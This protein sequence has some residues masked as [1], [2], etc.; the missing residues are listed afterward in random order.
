MF[1]LTGFSNT[2][3]NGVPLPFDI[4]VLPDG[5]NGRMLEICGRPEDV[6]VAEHVHDWLLATAERLWRQRKRVDSPQRAQRHF[7]LMI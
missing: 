1:L 5:R 7:R 6:A 4:A 3:A 2:S